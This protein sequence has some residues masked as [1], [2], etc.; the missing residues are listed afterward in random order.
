MLEFNVR[1][2]GGDFAHHVAPEL[3]GLEHI[4]LSNRTQLPAARAG[5]LEADAGDAHDLILVITHEVVGLTSSGA[6]HP[7]S[8]VAEIYIAVR[9]AHDQHIHA[10]SNVRAQ[11]RTFHEFGE[12]PCRAQVREQPELAAQP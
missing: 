2:A 8:L 5:G 12:D 9:F 10:A 3:R 1:K 7:A 4:G 6:R 11:Y